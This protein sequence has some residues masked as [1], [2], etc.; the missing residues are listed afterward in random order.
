MKYKAEIWKLFHPSHISIE[1]IVK[2]SN[3]FETSALLMFIDD[4]QNIFI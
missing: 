4:F 3:Y 1:Y 2:N